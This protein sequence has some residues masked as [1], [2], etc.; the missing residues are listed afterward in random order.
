VSYRN[1]S[2]SAPPA[3]D[4]T[5]AAK[6]LAARVGQCFDQVDHRK[7]MRGRPPFYTSWGQ[8]KRVQPLFNS[9]FILRGRRIGQVPGGTSRV[10]EGDAVL[11]DGRPDVSSNTVSS[12]SRWLRKS[13]VAGRAVCTH[14]SDDCDQTS[15]RKAAKSVKIRRMWQIY[16]IQIDGRFLSRFEYQGDS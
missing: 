5:K 8:F 2:V 9:K 6:L 11:L 10:V 16:I 1:L 3:R 12:A 14:R 7:N 4:K 13:Q 15:I